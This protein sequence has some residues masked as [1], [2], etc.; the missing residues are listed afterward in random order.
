MA[1][2]KS[3]QRRRGGGPE[4]APQVKPQHPK[5]RQLYAEWSELVGLSQNLPA[6]HR[7]S[8]IER[9]SQA[10]QLHTQFV[11]NNDQMALAQVVQLLTPTKEDPMA[12]H[13]YLGFAMK[14]LAMSLMP[15]QKLTTREQRL[16][17]ALRAK[18]QSGKEIAGR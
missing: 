8:A 1:L 10:A 7:D 11:E 14:S 16:T 2:D 3:M 13:K 4:P 5:V 17:Q 6:Q 9:L 12:V 18:T 15:N